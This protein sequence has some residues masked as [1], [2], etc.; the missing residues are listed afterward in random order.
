MQFL[1]LL[2]VTVIKL[3]VLLFY[4]RIFFVN[5]R[6]RVAVNIMCGL[7]LGWFITFFFATL[8]QTVPIS[9]NWELAGTGSTQ[10]T[11]INRYAMYISAAVLE[12]A[13]DIVTL[14]LP[15]FVIWRLQMHTTQKWQVSGIFLLGSL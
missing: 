9:G 2:A 14:V 1:Y 7:V 15:L 12:I 4:K 10:G 3:S 11:S 6:F 5:S 13:L 8:L